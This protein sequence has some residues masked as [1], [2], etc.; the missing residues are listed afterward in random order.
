MNRP[1]LLASLLL[2]VTVV[3]CGSDARTGEATDLAEA[4]QCPPVTVSG[5]AAVTSGPHP[6]DVIGLLVFRL[7]SL[8]IDLD[9]G[10]VW[11]NRAGGISINVVVGNEQPDV[12]ALSNE[13]GVEIALVERAYPRAALLQE[14]G[15]FRNQLVA[16]LPPD[17]SGIQFSFPY[18]PIQHC[19]QLVATVSDN[20]A[21]ERLEKA[22]VETGLVDGQDHLV[23]I[24]T[25]S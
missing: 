18:F 7:E 21:Y 20:E 25:L 1:R 19:V 13:F 9:G 6:S 5:A 17:F 3:G 10:D 11:I 14:A 23:T 12:E 16:E 8:D 22:L 24:D 2:A 15:R 4:W